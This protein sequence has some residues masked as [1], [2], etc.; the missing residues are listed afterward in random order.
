MIHYLEIFIIAI[1][2]NSYRTGYE[3]GHGDIS[4]KLHNNNG[5]FNFL[6]GIRN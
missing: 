1:C 2:H 5:L 6:Y 4:P 3:L